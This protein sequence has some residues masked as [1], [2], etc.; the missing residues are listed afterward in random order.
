MFV[1]ELL[2]K[3]ITS[4]LPQGKDR[5]QDTEVKTKVQRSVALLNKNLKQLMTTAVADSQNLTKLVFS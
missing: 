2:L 5:T 3:L 4:I 1:T